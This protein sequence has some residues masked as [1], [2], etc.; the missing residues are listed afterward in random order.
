MCLGL[1]SLVVSIAENQRPICEAL[2]AAGLIQY[3]GHVGSVGAAQ[4]REALKPL[5][6]NRDRLETLS[7]GGRFLVDGRGASRV[8]G[9]I[10]RCSGDDLIHTRN[11]LHEADACPVGF[12]TF[13]FAWIDRCR[14]DDVLALRNMPHVTVQ[15]RSRDVITEA[16][17]RKFLHEYQELDRYDFIL[18]DNSRSRYVGGFNIANLGSSPEIGN[19]IGD[20]DYLGK[21][22]AH[23]AM[24]SMLDYCR[25]RAGL[26]H[27]TSITRHDNPRNIALNTKLGFRLGGP[28]QGDYV[29]M[30]LEL[31]RPAEETPLQRDDVESRG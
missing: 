11:A 6:E 27:L 8:A 5:L 23:K 26:R 9:V 2:A 19:Y 21:G 25:S 3:V 17:H 30:T 24:Q 16:E 20:V 31:V 28:R 22:I 18:I 15:M 14:A 13:T 7:S 4:I 29:V 1:P 12:D 10:L